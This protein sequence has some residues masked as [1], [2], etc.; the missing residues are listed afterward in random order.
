MYIY[1]NFNHNAFYVKVF[2]FCN[3]DAS[4]KRCTVH[5]CVGALMEK[6]SLVYIL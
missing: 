4:N 3:S 1:V 5:T 2:D 6:I